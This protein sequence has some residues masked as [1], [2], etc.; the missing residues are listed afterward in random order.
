MKPVWHLGINGGDDLCGLLQHLEFHFRI[1]F[2]DYYVVIIQI[3][4]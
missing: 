3:V 2:V 1:L 4:I